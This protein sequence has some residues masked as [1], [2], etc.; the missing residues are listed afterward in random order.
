MVCNDF[1]FFDNPKIDYGEYVHRFIESKC[2]CILIFSTDS[3]QDMHVVPVL[4]HTLNSELWYPEAEGF[5]RPELAKPFVHA[6]KWVDNFIIHDDNFGMYLCL[7]IDSLRRMTLPTTDPHFRVYYA[8]GICPFEINMP[9]SDAENAAAISLRNVI[10]KV[11]RDAGSLRFW[12]Q[13]LDDYIE[14]RTLVFRSC[15]VDR[16]QFGDHF[17]KNKDSE[18]KRFSAADIDWMLSD[19]PMK[20]WLCEISIP[21]L[22]STNKS[23]LADAIY[24]IDDPPISKKEQVHDRLQLLRMPGYAYK[25]QQEPREL[26]VKSHYP[27]VRTAETLEY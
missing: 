7:P 3:V 10:D 21:G 19:L 2:P 26:G 20:F 18:G 14:K 22:Y 1:D 6:S 5:Y 11:K 9:G 8:M 24:G 16:D 12:V 4:G 13:I 27:L 17:K 25:P 23:K 15:I